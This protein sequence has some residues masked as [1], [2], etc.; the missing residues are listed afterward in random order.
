MLL[1][2]QYLQLGIL[3]K[4]SLQRKRQVISGRDSGNTNC[5]IVYAF[6]IKVVDI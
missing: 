1:S 4:I 5:N 3:Q 6:D 2:Y